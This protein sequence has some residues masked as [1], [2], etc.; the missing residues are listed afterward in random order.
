MLVNLETGS[1]PEKQSATGCFRDFEK[2]YFLE[3]P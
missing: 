1:R 3:K 2:N